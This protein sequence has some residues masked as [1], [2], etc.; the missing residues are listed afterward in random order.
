MSA[1]AMSF[2]LR[3]LTI[4]GVDVTCQCAEDVIG[5]LSALPVTVTVTECWMVYKRHYRQVS[6]ADGRCV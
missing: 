4:G 3:V 2:T 6:E 1:N 5:N